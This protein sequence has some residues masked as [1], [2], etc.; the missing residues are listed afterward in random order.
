M[1]HLLNINSLTL[2]ESEKS[3][4][5]WKVM[6]VEEGLS[7]NG[8]YYP[9]QVLKKAKH[10]FEKSKVC[11]YEWKGK[12]YDHLPIEI[13]KIRPEGFP[14]QIAGWL[15][16]VQF[17]SLN[18]EGKEVKG[19][20]GLLHIHKGAEWLKDLLVTSW[21]KGLR[22][23]LGLS[24]NAEGPQTMQII[25]SKPLTMVQAISKVFSVDLVS[26]PAAGGRF[27]QLLAS[28]NEN[29]RRNVDMFKEIV[30]ILKQHRPDLLE[31]IDVENITQE[32]ITEILESLF[33]EKEEDLKKKEEER[34]KAEEDKK[35]K[36]AQAQDDEKK[37]LDSAVKAAQKAIEEAEEEASGVKGVIDLIK[38]EKLPMAVALLQKAIKKKESDDEDDE[39]D[40]FFKKKKKKKDDEEED[41]KESELQKKVEELLHQNKVTEC[42]TLLKELLSSSGL[43][44]VV[45]AKI[46]KRFSGIVFEESALEESI[47]EEKETL[48]KLSESGEIIDLGDDEAIEIIRTRTGKDRLQASLDL[49]FGY[50]PEDKEKDIYDGIKPFSGL[51]E[52]YVR[53][54]GDVEISGRIP[55]GRLQEAAS[56]D[57]NYMLG[58]TLNRRM[59]KEY[60]GLPELWRNIANV[61]SVKDFKMQELIRW[62]GFGILPEVI[63]ART[64]QGT[65]TDTA[66][67][68]YPE[69]GFPVDTEQLY[70]VGTKGGM[71]TVTRRAII[72][73]DLRQLGKIPSK[74]AKAANRTLNQFVFDLMLNMSAYVINA[75]TKWPGTTGTANE[76]ALFAS[77]HNNYQTTALGFDALND[78]L[79]KG[80]NQGERGYM[81]AITDNPLSDSATTINV[82]TGTGQYFKAGDIVEIFGEYIKVRSV[83]TDA[84]TV[85]RGILGTTA[86]SHVTASKIYKITAILGLSDAT[87]WVPRSLKGTAEQLINSTLHPESGENAVNTLKGA[88]KITVSP[89][90][91]G[92]ENNYYISYGKAEVELIEIGF[93]NGKQTPEILVQDQPTVG[94]VFVYDTLRYKVRHEYGGAVPDYRAFAAGIVA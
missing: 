93:L 54:T 17:E 7:K 5:T 62:G 63:A 19:L 36:E 15:D 13:E 71:V 42:R 70:G 18:I 14:K 89:Y 60:K 22:Q 92:D 35:N 52:A 67:P 90:L 32:K 69:L 76:T 29:E 88:C 87:L 64:T 20:T 77:A 33:K 55:Q 26:N 66:T 72:N 8:K 75:G 81:S 47:K 6:I 84:L 23:F 44:E 1:K 21:N 12:H 39:D 61:V 37:A 79:T 34:K 40:E 94:N 65:A 59:L 3:G 38:A 56:G 30:D 24:I 43:P 41:E 46:N 50:E 27:T 86:A 48:A 2:L 85:T 16:N 53:I 31:G 11:F 49:A 82:T 10:L 73:D 78:L 51:R 58:Y 68:S 83:S 45:Q 91:G 80:Y 9:A 28:Y 25:N 57:F 74:L 4:K